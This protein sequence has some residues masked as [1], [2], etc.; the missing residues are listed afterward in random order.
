[1]NHLFSTIALLLVEHNINICWFACGWNSR[2]TEEGWRYY[3]LESGVRLLKETNASVT[4]LYLIAEN[5][6]LKTNIQINAINGIQCFYLG[7]H[8]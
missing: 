3:S 4:K 2:V 7:F 1:M 6:H 5:C 8:T